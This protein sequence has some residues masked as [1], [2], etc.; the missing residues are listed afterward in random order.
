MADDEN[1]MVEEVRVSLHRVLMSA[2]DSAPLD[3]WEPNYFERQVKFLSL[4]SL[5]SSI[6]GDSATGTEEKNDASSQSTAKFS[7]DGRRALAIGFAADDSAYKKGQDNGARHWK[8]GRG[9]RGR[10]GRHGCRGDDEQGVRTRAKEK[11]RRPTV[12]S[13][14]FRPFPVES[15]TPLLGM[16]MFIH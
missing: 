8:R 10:R 7:G 13:R 2:L 15:G 9:R 1:Y 4:Q 12:A 6:R 16:H 5:S 3:G 11:Q 14:S